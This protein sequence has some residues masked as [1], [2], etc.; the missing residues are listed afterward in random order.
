MSNNKLLSIVV[1]TKNRY[2]YLKYLIG[3]VADLHSDEIELV[4]QDNSENNIEFV[5]YLEELNYSF[6]NYNHTQG[7][8]PMAINSDKAIMNSSGEYVCFLGDDDGLTK[9]VIDCVKWMS[10]NNVEAVKSA[11]VQYSW[12]DI[13]EGTEGAP[14]A[15]VRY[16][17]FT[18]EVQYRNPY[19]EL[20]KV[21]KKGI[22]DRGEMPLVYHSIVKRSALD[23]VYKKVGTYFPGNS[24]DISNAVALSLTVKKYAY[25]N[26]P[27]AFSGASVYHGGGVHATN[28]AGQP[29]INEIPWFRPNAE[30][31]WDK[32]VPRVAASSLIWADSA[33]SALNQMNAGELYNEIS[34]N[35][36]YS[37]FCL[38]N[39][40]YRNAVLEVCDSKLSF[41]CNYYS[42]IVEKYVKALFRR[43]GW[44][45]GLLE[46]MKCENNINDVIEATAFLEKKATEVHYPFN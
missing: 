41:Y 12:P 2:K 35:K 38:R 4:I 6:I 20:I 37:Y 26:F 44:R 11:S 19:K 23:K 27:L 7:Q 29:S 39:P 31:N 3:L 18:G 32:K 9:Y 22:V 33:I 1:P 10:E 5:K 17:S 30:Q 13:S 16:K 36:M 21:L 24:P 42:S 15:V 25:I 34:F 46:K 28:K 8:I 40:G 45:I 14:S 43:I